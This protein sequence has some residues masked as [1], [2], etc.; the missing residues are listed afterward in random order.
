MSKPITIPDLVPSV[1]QASI[2]EVNYLVMKN[3]EHYAISGNAAGGNTDD[4]AIAGEV[5]GGKTPEEYL[6]PIVVLT[7]A[8]YTK[9]T[10]IIS[11]TLASS[12]SYSE[13]NVTRMQLCFTEDVHN[14]EVYLKSIKGE[15]APVSPRE[16]AVSFTNLDARSYEFDVVANGCLL[17][18]KASVT[19]KMKGTTVKDPLG[20]F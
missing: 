8:T 2:G 5:H 4:N 18:Q 16:W 7:S 15:C 3:Y 11:F 13:R 14:L 1:E 20:D 12:T 6:V 19:V 9:P 10:S 17:T